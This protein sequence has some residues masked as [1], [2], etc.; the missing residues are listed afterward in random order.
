M[1]E[2]PRR[3]FITGLVSLIAA[4]AIVRATNLMPV[5]VLKLN[6]IQIINIANYNLDDEII[7]GT[8]KLGDKITFESF[9]YLVKWMNDG[10]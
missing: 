9:D 7:Y 8:L 10:L 3:Q 6:K 4:P 5:K 1:I 2:L